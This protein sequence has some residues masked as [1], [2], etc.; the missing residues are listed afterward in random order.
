VAQP[1]EPNNGGDG[2]DSLAGLAVGVTIAVM[3]VLTVGMYTCNHTC[4]RGNTLW[5]SS[6]PELPTQPQAISVYENPLHLGIAAGSTSAY[7]PA[8]Q[9]HGVQLDSELYMVK[10]TA[11]SSADAPYAVFRDPGAGVSVLR[12]TGGVTYAIPLEAGLSAAPDYIEVSGGT[13]YM[14]P[15]AGVSVFQEAGGVTY[16]I[17]LEVGLSAAPDYMM[18][19]GGSTSSAA[20]PGTSVVTNPTYAQSDGAASAS[21]ITV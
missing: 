13:D 18:I 21:D 17:P 14:H 6:L 5:H 9:H 16:A 8:T 4:K 2:S 11:P 10:K 7:G 3:L 15:G 1:F 12:E 20:R 19:E